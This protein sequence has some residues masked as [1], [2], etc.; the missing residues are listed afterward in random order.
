MRYLVFAFSIA[1]ISAHANAEKILLPDGMVYVGEVSSGKANGFGTLTSTKGSSFTGVFVNNK[2][3]GRHLFDSNDGAK[4]YVFWD[5]GKK[6]GTSKYFYD[7]KD[8]VGGFDEFGRRSG[9]G[10][11]VYDNGDVYEGLWSKDE[12]NGMG[13]YTFKNGSVF[14]GEFRDGMH[15]EK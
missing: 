7:L 1:F 10:I 14:E 9:Q 2:A 3:H 8:Y 12:P 11:F 4:M 13:V 5:H 15:I 6:V